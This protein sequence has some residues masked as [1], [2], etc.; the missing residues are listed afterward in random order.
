M[1]RVHALNRREYSGPT[2]I[3]VS[4]GRMPRFHSLIKSVRGHVVPLEQHR[5]WKASNDILLRIKGLIRHE[6]PWTELGSHLGMLV[7]LVVQRRY[8][9][10][11]LRMRL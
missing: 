1:M 6:L 3:F 5:A 7:V 8:K 10:T 4:E 9:L 11:E 2:S